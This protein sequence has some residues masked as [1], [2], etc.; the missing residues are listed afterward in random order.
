MRAKSPLT[1][2]LPFARPLA[3]PFGAT[4]LRSA[5]L[6][7]A[8]LSSARVAFCGGC[9]SALLGLRTPLRP[10]RETGATRAARPPKEKRGDFLSSKLGEKL[11][12]F[13]Y[14][15]RRALPPIQ[16]EGRCRARSTGEPAHNSASRGLRLVSPDGENRSPRGGRNR[17]T[18]PHDDRT[19]GTPVATAFGG[20]PCRARGI[21]A[22]R[23]ERRGVR[24]GSVGSLGSKVPRSLLDGVSRP[25]CPRL[26]ERPQRSA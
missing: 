8:R 3:C 22:L 25:R 15:L 1:A 11:P 21:F 18:T 9:S 17:E 19:R 10:F 4:A 24:L 5:T 26:A 20:S 14:R 6:A 2:E 23:F 12:R 13:S 7:I 16:R